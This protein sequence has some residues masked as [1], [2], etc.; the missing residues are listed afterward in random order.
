MSDHFHGCTGSRRRR[1][2]S[3]CNA[4]DYSVI[5][6]VIPPP[7]SKR[8]LVEMVAAAVAE[9]VMMVAVWKRRRIDWPWRSGAIAR[10]TQEHWVVVVVHRAMQALPCALAGVKSAVVAVVVV[11]GLVAVVVAVVG[12]WVLPLV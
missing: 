9:V 11:V 7:T 12:V 3:G 1:D 8:P 2:Y 4:Y 6:L 5:L 10:T